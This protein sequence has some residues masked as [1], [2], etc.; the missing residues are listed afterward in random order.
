MQDN[1]RLEHSPSPEL[2]RPSRLAVTV[3]AFAMGGVSIYTLQRFKGGEVAQ[4]PQTP[5]PAIPKIETVTALGRLEP[6]GEVIELSAP[7]M[8][9]EGSRVEQLLVKQGD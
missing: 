6:K 1:L 5:P 9:A 2:A 4:K 8:G 3:A 7:S